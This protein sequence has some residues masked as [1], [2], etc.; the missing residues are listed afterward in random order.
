MATV[1]VR[2]ALVDD[3]ES[4]RDVL[5]AGYM[6]YATAFPVENWGPYLENILDIEGRSD[7]SVLI[8]AEIDGRIVGCVSYYP[9]G[10]ETYYP[11]PTYTQHWPPEWASFRLLAVDPVTRGQGVGRI[12]TEACIERARTEGAPVIGLH[13]TKEMDIARAMYER[14]GFVRCPEYDF[15]PGPT[16]LV[17]AY[18]LDLT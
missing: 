9:A 4:A 8:V 3:F 15:R 14:R 5:R 11:S 7:S 17:E 1:T 13:T 12:L 18:R 16:V 6:Q 10:A 2:D